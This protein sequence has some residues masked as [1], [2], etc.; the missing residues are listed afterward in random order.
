MGN[1]FSSLNAI[2]MW[3]STIPTSWEGT[4]MTNVTNKSVQTMKLSFIVAS[5]FSES[6]LERLGNSCHSSQP[7]SMTKVALE[8][9]VYF[10]WINDSLITACV[11]LGLCKEF[12]SV[13]LCVPLNIGSEESSKEEKRH[14]IGQSSS[15]HQKLHI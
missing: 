15:W 2:T 11:Q 8:R 1:G 5:C 4:L 7:T 3:Q 13:G 10:F 9:F 12:I 6:H 14:K